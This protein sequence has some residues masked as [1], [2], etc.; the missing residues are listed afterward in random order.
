[1]PETPVNFGPDSG[2]A[3][4]TNASAGGLINCFVESAPNAKTEFSVY[5]TPGLTA[6]GTLEGATGGVRGGIAIGNSTFFVV[7]GETLYSVASGG[8]ATSIGT[9]TGT[10]N[11]VMAYNKAD[12]F[13]IAIAADGKEYLYSDGSVA[14]IADADLPSSSI[15]VAY[16]DGYFVWL[17]ADG[18]MYHSDINDGTAYNALNF[19]EAEAKPDAARA[20]GV[21][22][23]RLAVFG[24]ESVEFFYNAG[25]AEGFVFSPQPGALIDRGILAKNCW[26]NFDNSIAWIDQN[27]IVVRGEGTIARTIGSYPVHFDI[28]DTIDRQE[29]SEIVVTT[30]SFAGHEILQIWSER[31]CWCYDA[32]TQKWFKRE[33]QDSNTWKGRHIFRVF[34][35]LIVGSA[36][37]GTLYEQSDATYDEDGDQLIRT[38]Y[39]NYLYSNASRVRHDALYLDIETGVGLS[40]ASESEDLNPEIIISWSDDGGRSYVGNRQIGIGAQG[41]YSTRVVARRLGTSSIQGRVYKVSFTSSRPFT[42]V[43]ALADVEV[44]AK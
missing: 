3:R 34:N 21:V 19:A 23:D 4:S 14:E 8:N 35:K 44:L 6:F 27:G 2:P 24:V 33:S 1:M 12:P 16:L 31:W 26:A 30:W 9:I 25:N 7:A 20:I 43:G 32:S 18:V 40:E 42:L 13:E 36:T 37:A 29:Q 22:G 17:Y 5:S 39:S 41:E 38:M 15:G 28:Q 11:V 10:D